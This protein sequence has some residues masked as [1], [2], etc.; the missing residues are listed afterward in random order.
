MCQKGRNTRDSPSAHT[1]ADCCQPALCGPCTTVADGACPCTTYDL[2]SSASGAREAA[3][4]MR[5]R[6]HKAVRGRG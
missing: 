3:K 4:Q 5:T 2:E 1:H 6:I